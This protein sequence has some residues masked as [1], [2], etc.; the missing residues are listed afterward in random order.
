MR[1]LLVNANTSEAV[2]Q[3]AADE[4]RATASSGTEIVPVT[5]AFGARV[6]RSKPDNAIALHA[7]L[8]AVARQ[9]ADCDAV[10]VAVSLDTAV[11]ELRELLDIP[12]LGMTGAALAQA[13]ARGAAFGVVT[14]G[15]AMADLFASRFPGHGAAAVESIDIGPGEILDERSTAADLLSRAVSRLK[16][17][18]LSVAVPVGAT[19]TGLPRSLRGTAPLPILDGIA[20]AVE[21]AERLA[22][23]VHARA[24]P[25]LLANG[26]YAGLSQALSALMRGR[27]K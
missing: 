15:G 16:E 7:C 5:A 19:F 21:G 9:V 8:D 4:A 26:E 17:R 6:I 25:P 2:T 12:V 14:A 24:R 23:G 13:R 20:C 11:E 18:G 27:R 22:K 10:V 1:I 3:I